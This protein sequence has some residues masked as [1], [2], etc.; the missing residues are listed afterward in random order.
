V[1]AHPDGGLV[2]VFTDPDPLGD[3][4]FV[5]PIVPVARK[6]VLFTPAWPLVEKAAVGDVDLATS[7][8]NRVFCV[9]DFGRFVPKS[10]RSADGMIFDPTDLMKSHHLAVDVLTRR[11]LIAL[12]P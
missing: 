9:D 5:P 3:G 12:V 10:V 11:S 7:P 6:L 1:F 8:R 2:E 4:R